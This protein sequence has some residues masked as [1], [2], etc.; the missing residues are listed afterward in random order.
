[1]KRSRS[2]IIAIAALALIGGSALAINLRKNENNNQTAST[3]PAAQQSS[4]DIAKTDAEKFLEQYT[5]ED[6]DRIFVANMIEH[7]SGAIEMANMAIENAKHDELK[8]MARDIVAAQ[9]KEVEQLKNWQ[10]AWGF[11]TTSGGEM[12]DHSAMGMAGEMDTMTASLQGKSGDEFD[13][14]FITAMIQHHSSAVGMSRPAAKNAGRQEI[15]DL[16][17]AIIEAQDAEIAQLRAWLS[18]WGYSS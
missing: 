8:G 1:M 4:V 18:E 3:Q 6:F 17:R 7:H 15:K 14:A 2:I 10:S 16:A 5:G 12:M 11:P 13:K 9:T